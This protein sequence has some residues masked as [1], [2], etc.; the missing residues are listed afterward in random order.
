MENKKISAL[1]YGFVIISPEKF[2]QCRKNM[3]GGY[4]G[5]EIK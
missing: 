4:M 3:V 5:L 2:E 1:G